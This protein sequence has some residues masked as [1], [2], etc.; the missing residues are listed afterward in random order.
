MSLSQ[1]VEALHFTL[2]DVIHSELIFVQGEVS[3]KVHLCHLSCGRQLCQYHL[4]KK[5]SFHRQTAR[6]ALS[7][8]SWHICVGLTLAS[9]ASFIDQFIY[10]WVIL[11]LN[12][13]VLNSFP[14]SLKP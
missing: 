12:L 4:F 6:A 13:Y 1:S 8:S 2:K 10:P 3:T 9:Q 7:K 5:L 11:F 14:H